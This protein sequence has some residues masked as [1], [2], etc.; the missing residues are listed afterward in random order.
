MRDFEH[1]R[2]IKA[3]VVVSVIGRLG[4][5]TRPYEPGTGVEV[6][7]AWVAELSLLGTGV[8]ADCV[9]LDPCCGA[10]EEGA[11]N[12]GFGDE[13]FHLDGLVVEGIKMRRRRRRRR[14]A[15]A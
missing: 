11:D 10:G 15:L 9:D 12:A 13:R 5:C 6:S 2:G 8:C 1:T 7:I 3:L 4:F 14:E